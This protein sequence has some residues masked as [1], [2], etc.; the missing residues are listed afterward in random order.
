MKEWM[1]TFQM[2][3]FSLKS[4][5]STPVPYFQLTIQS[6]PEMHDS[7]IKEYWA[8]P[9]TTPFS[10]STSWF[11]ESSL[12]PRGLC[13]FTSASIGYGGVNRFFLAFGTE[14]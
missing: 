11:L 7:S 3:T 12:Y 5:S 4:L 2:I 6:H 1:S 10:S 13:P 8:P 14:I 9:S